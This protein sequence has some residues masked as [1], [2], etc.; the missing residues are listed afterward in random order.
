MTDTPA[1]LTMIV[2]LLETADAQSLALS[3]TLVMLKAQFAAHIL[4]AEQSE[5]QNTEIRD[6]YECPECGNDIE[7]LGLMGKFPTYACVSCD[8]RGQLRSDSQG[9][10]A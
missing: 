8:F 3:N 9:H 1:N 10:S 4:K 5:E 7:D 2:S 6:G